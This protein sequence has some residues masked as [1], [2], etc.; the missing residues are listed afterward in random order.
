LRRLLG[1]ERRLDRVGL[2]SR[3]ET[4]DRG[5]G[6]A[7]HTRHRHDAGSGGPTIDEHGAG[8][9]LAESAP[10]LGAVEPELSKSDQK[11]LLGVPGLYGSGST[12]DS[13]A[14]CGHQPAPDFT[15]TAPRRDAD[16]VLEM[17]IRAA[18]V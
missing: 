16:R 17:E 1:D 10:R 6:A 12:V 14:I 4:F 18:R 8:A 3:A 15:R 11:R 9:A 2:R 5:D 13:A 7:R